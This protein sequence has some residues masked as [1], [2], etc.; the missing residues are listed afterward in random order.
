MF[1]AALS[2]Q[3]AQHIELSCFCGYHRQS[4]VQQRLPVILERHRSVSLQ[5]PPRHVHLSISHDLVF[6]HGRDQ[7]GQ[8]LR[9][10]RFTDWI[11]CEVNPPQHFDVSIGRRIHNCRYDFAIESSFLTPQYALHEPL[12]D[13]YMSVLD[14]TLPNGSFAVLPE[15]A[16]E[17]AGVLLLRQRRRQPNQI[18]DFTTPRSSDRGVHPIVLVRGLR[19]LVQQLDVSHFRGIPQKHPRSP[20]FQL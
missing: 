3:P 6:E 17:F 2:Q 11:E 4:R 13:V 5:K 7:M 8:F 18:I 14:R 1:G 10:H 20:S 15:C 9:Q 16:V 12:E 19:E